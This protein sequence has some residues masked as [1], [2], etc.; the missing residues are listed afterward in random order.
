MAGTDEAALYGLRQRFIEGTSALRIHLREAV[1][2]GAVQGIVLRATELSAGFAENKDEIAR[3]L[4][5][6]GDGTEHVGHTSHDGEEQGRGHRDFCVADVIVVLHTVFTGDTRDTV[7]SAIV[8]EGLVG[9]HELREFVWTIRRPRRQ[10]RVRPA[11][12]IET[13]NVAQASTYG[14]DVTDGLINGTGYHVIRVNIAVARTDT[15]G[16]DHP[17]H[18]V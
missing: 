4:D 15:V 14:N 12:V 3:L 11:E 16:N 9:T 10:D 5:V 18:G 17:L 13:R 1:A 7:G 6:H 2:N 8:V